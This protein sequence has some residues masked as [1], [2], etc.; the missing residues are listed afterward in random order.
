[1][2][3]AVLDVIFRNIYNSCPHSVFG[4]FVNVVDFQFAEDVFAVGYYS[5]E[6]EIAVCCYFFGRFA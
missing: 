6:T 2:Q 5:M 4:R 3:N 1:M